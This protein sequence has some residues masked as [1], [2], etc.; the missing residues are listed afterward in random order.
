LRYNFLPSFARRKGRITKLQEKNLSFLSD[1][2]L[3]DPNTLNNNPS[4]D[5]IALEIGFGNGED[6]FSFA[7]EKNNTLFLASE[8][9]KSGIGNLI[10]K[11]RKHSLENV[12]IHEGDIRDLILEEKSFK[13][14]EVY[15]ICPDP[16]PKDRHHKRR[17]LNK[18]FFERIQPCLKSNSFIFLSTDW[19]NYAEQIQDV[20]RGFEDE[21]SIETIK[22][23]PGRELS[24]FQK[25]GI[26][27]G[28]EI[29]NFKLS[30]I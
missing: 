16:W 2:S 22:Q 30:L 3:D 4:F 7:K 5:K 11:I 25:K 13:F 21:F 28:R 20:L 23:I 9:Y 24:K 18:D 17:L 10:G 14:D 19:K 6:F 1:Y 27:E 26:K 29:Y 15:I 8:V 12:Y